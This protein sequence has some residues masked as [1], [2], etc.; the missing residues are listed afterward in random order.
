MFESYL[1]NTLKRLTLFEDFNEDFNGA[2]QG[3]TILHGELV[4]TANPSVGAAL[5]KTSLFLERLSA[6]FLIDAEGF[7]QAYQPGWI[8]KDL[9]SLALTSRLLNSTEDPAEINNMLHAAG[10]AARNMPKL[11]IMEIWSGGRWH[12]S[13]FRYHAT[14]DFTTVT[15]H[16]VWNLRLESRVIETWKAAALEYSRHELCVEVYRM[17]SGNIQSYGDA[18][19][20]LKLKQQVLHPVSLHQIRMEG[21]NYYR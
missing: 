12:A 4:R 13:V 8:W 19:D 15:W 17:P 18:I 16:S 3:D 20:H 6:S 11:R 21:R 5:A 14:D 1:P 2:F 9:V 10:V 7:F